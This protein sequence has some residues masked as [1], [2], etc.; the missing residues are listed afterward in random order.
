MQNRVAK[1][2]TKVEGAYAFAKSAADRILQGTASA[3]VVRQTRTTEKGRPYDRRFERHARQALSLGGS[4]AVVRGQMIQDARFFLGDAAA[5]TMEIPNIDWFKKQREQLGIESWLWAF[6]RI[7]RADFILQFGFDE[8]GFDRIGTFNQWCLIEENNKPCIV[9]IET[10]GILVG[11][12]A[13]ECRDHIRDVWNR[14]QR[15]ILTLR[16]Y[17]DGLQP[18]LADELVPVRH[19]GVQLL[20]IGSTMHDTVNPVFHRQ[21]SILLL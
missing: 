2:E 7:A 8:T 14:G 12:T 3:H 1:M 5:S 10:G 15:A 19:G 13:D 9:N 4:A 16:E 21:P 20:K 11:G 18:G 6:V 17:L